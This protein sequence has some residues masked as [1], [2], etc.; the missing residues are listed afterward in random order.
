VPYALTKP[1]RI[2]L[3]GMGFL[4]H[5][6]HYADNLPHGTPFSFGQSR[7]GRGHGALALLDGQFQLLQ[8]V[9]CLCTL[10]L[11]GGHQGHLQPLLGPFRSS[12]VHAPA[13][14]NQLRYLTHSPLGQRGTQNRP[15][16]SGGGQRQTSFLGSQFESVQWFA[17]KAVGGHLAYAKDEP[18]EQDNGCQSGHQPEGFG[19]LHSLLSCTGLCC[20]KLGCLRQEA[21]PSLCQPLRRQGWCLVEIG[22]LLGYLYQGEHFLLGA[23]TSR[24]FLQCFFESFRLPS[25]HELPSPPA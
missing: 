4:A 21:L 12:T 11:G 9:F 7:K 1:V 8:R 16:L 20:A 24:C 15:C 22:H 3:T 2:S 18:K 10:H 19:H 23:F 25:A 13:L 17:G 5:S 14:L 6:F